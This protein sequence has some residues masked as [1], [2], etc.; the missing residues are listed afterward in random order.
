MI[1]RSIRTSLGP[2]VLTL[3][4]A[5]C[6]S[7]PYVRGE[8][9][10]EERELTTVVVRKTTAPTMERSFASVDGSSDMLKM[11]AGLEYEVS[12]DSG[13]NLAQL[14]GSASISGMVQLGQE[15]IAESYFAFFYGGTHEV[16]RYEAGAYSAFDL[17][18]DF[19]ELPD[20]T[21]LVAQL[22]T[23]FQQLQ[24]PLDANGRGI[25]TVFLESVELDLEAEAVVYRYS[26]YPG[27]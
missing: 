19:D 7:V 27:P 24:L 1:A 25:G 23:M 14:S 16:Y 20:S 10:V 15:P 12:S 13:V 9:V 22:N 11:V 3:V 4:L 8:L 21:A 17:V 18:I 2:V 26:L 6:A 5:G